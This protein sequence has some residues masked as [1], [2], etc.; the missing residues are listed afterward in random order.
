MK[1]VEAQKLLVLIAISMMVAANWNPIYA[2]DGKPKAE[3]H[4]ISVVL[5]MLKVDASDRNCTC[6]ELRVTNLTG[7]II[8]IHDYMYRVYVYGKDGEAPTTLRQRQMTGRFKPGDVSLSADEMW[9][10]QIAPGNF[11]FRKFQLPSLYELKAP[12]SYTA[13]AEVMEPGTEKW[14]RTNT[15][16]F[17]IP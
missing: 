15:V 7:N 16:T 9:L 8:A 5:S 12:G 17:T 14:L 10:W 3:K 2:Q 6:V 13:Y 11:D 1:R 4:S